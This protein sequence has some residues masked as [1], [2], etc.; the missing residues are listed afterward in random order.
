MLNVIPFIQILR[1]YSMSVDSILRSIQ[2]NSLIDFIA[3]IIIKSYTTQDSL[4]AID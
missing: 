4:L 1:Q 3:T 2:D